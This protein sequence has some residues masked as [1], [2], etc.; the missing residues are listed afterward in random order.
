MEKQKEQEEMFSFLTFA[1]CFS[2]SAFCFL[3][4]EFLTQSSLLSPQSL[5]TARVTA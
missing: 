5:I 1:F 3:P 2:Y 4:A